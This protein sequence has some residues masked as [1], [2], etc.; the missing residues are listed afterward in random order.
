VVSGAA[1]VLATSVV[2][3]TVVG[4]VGETE[5]SAAA[6]VVVAPSVGFAVVGG[7]LLVGV[8]EKRVASVAVEAKESPGMV[9]AE[10]VSAPGVVAVTVPGASVAATV[11]VVAAE[12][13]AGPTVVVAIVVKF[14]NSSVGAG[15]GVVPLPPGL[16]LS[17]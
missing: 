13:E 15:L 2:P 4:S 11:V 3:M 5:V 10:V 14:P 17:S 7:P 12:E 6:S 9:V 16:V 8:V 1:V